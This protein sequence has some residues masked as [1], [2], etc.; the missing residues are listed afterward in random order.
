MPVVKK[1][2]E[3][4]LIYT[5][6]ARGQLPVT[7]ADFDKIP[8]IVKSPDCEIIGIKRKCLICCSLFILMLYFLHDD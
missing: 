5:E 6:K 1:M 2:P 3:K 4:S 7:F 8:N